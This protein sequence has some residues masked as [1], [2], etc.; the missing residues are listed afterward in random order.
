M[1]MNM[2]EIERAL[3]ALRLSGIRATLETRVL[4]A[5]ANQEPFL[6]TFSLI[7]QDKPD[8]R[9]SRLMQRRYQQS[10]LGERITLADFDWRFNPTLPRAACF[11]LH[12]LRFVAEG[13]NALIIGEPG[14][15]TGHI[16]G[17]GLPSHAAGTQG[18]LPG[19]RQRVRAVRT[20]R[21]RRAAAPDAYASRR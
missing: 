14:T 12:T 17:G 4:Q 19:G 7:L 6:D 11:D 8:R 9:R 16:E 18:A 5:Q 10:G 15:G 3:C 2:I 13:H 20:R 21:R 1:S